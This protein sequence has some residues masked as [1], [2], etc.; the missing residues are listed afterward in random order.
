[1]ISYAAVACV[2]STRWQRPVLDARFSSGRRLR[3]RRQSR[4]TWSSTKSARTAWVRHRRV[5]PELDAVFEV[6]HKSTTCV[7]ECCR[8]WTRCSKYWTHLQLVS[9][10]AAGTGR[11]VRSTGHVYNLWPATTV[12]ARI[13]A[14]NGNYEGLPSATVTF[15]TK[16]GGLSY[17]HI[18]YALWS[19]TIWSFRSTPALRGRW[20]ECQLCWG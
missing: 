12:S 6:L 3:D 19:Q 7:P 10:S 17:E 4:S 18:T 9:L 5:L 1:V 11:G 14:V 13:V 16:E 15:T 20:I 2:S 8:D